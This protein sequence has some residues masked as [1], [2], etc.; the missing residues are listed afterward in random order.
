VILAHH[1]L[2]LVHLLTLLRIYSLEQT[3]KRLAN[4]RLEID[5]KRDHCHCFQ[6]QRV[7]VAHHA[8]SGRVTSSAHLADC[9]LPKKKD[10][11]GIEKG[12]EKKK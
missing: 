10:K 1:N 2:V 12:K 9:L 11:K 5:S 3:S 8:K 6:E 4:R 7:V